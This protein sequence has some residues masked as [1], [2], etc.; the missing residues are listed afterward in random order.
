M[1][2]RLGLFTIIVFGEVV[3]GVVNGISKVKNLDF[4]AWLNF[5]FAIS[6]VFALWWIFFTLTSNRHAKTGFVVA[7]WLE[8]LCIPTLMSLG[9]I[10][11]RFS[12]LF[13][14]YE[15]N[16]SLNILFNCAVAAFLIGINLMMG[17]L[18]YH[19][20]FRSIERPVRM[21]LLVTAIVLIGWSL[22]NFKLDTQYYLLV[23]LGILVAEII[24]LNF[25]YYNL[26]AEARRKMENAGSESA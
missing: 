7:T 10:A 25:F 9:L 21:S 18:E 2:E 15:I 12:Y 23:V 16:Q 20:I 14:S 13:D 17:L 4:S 6:I 22:V 1:S 8:L 5:A 11:A 19:D 26:D 3:L 24:C